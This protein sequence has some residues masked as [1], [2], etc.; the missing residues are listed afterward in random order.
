[1]PTNRSQ[2]VDTHILTVDVEDW[3]HLLEVKGGYSHADWDTLP[4]RVVA[5]TDRLLSLFAEHRLQATF[6]FIGWVAERNR[7][8]VRQIAEAGHEVGSHSYWH[9]LVA[10][11]DRASFRQDLE[12]SRKALEDITGGPVRGFR[13]PGFSIT[14]DTAWAF[15][16]ILEQG[17]TY[18]SS[19]WPGRSMYGGFA[20]PLDGP[21]LLRCAAGDLIEIP[22]STRVFGLPLPY[23]GGGYLRLLPEWLIGACIRTNARRGIPTALYVHPRDFDERQPRMQ[24]PATR[25]FRSYVGLAGA[26]RKLRG[27]L[28]RFQ[29]VSAS[30]WIGKYGESARARLLDVRSTAAASG[31]SADD[32]PVPSPPPPPVPALA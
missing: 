27:L 32:S 8:L 6:F 13:A 12:R 16:L 4:S 15:D 7:D 2:P 28:R 20:T 31:S 29:W 25:T 3:F 26:Q 17:F 11:H 24:L 5:N 1:M 21:H 30:T 14:P 18:D 19:V 9:E 10:R 22:A 23:S